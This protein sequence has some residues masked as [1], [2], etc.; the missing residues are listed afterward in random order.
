MTDALDYTV[1]DFTP[2]TTEKNEIYVSKA[3]HAAMIE[4]DEEGVT[5]AAYTQLELAEGAAE[6][7]EEIDFVVDRPFMFVVTSRDGSILF[8][9]IVQNIQ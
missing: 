3:E 1:S 8:S 4:I 9:G 7:N 6:P 2:L 5:G